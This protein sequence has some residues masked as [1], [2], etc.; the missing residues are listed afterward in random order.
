MRGAVFFSARDLAGDRR[1]FATKIGRSHYARPAIIPAA[2]K[3][4][5]PAPPSE[6]KAVT[7]RGPVSVRWHGP[8]AAASYAVY[9]VEGKK[10][11]CAPI[12]PRTLIATVRGGSATD[13]AARPGATYTYYV[14][15][16]DRTHRESV[17]AKGAT[18]TVP[19]G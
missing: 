4:R 12:D 17:P 2:G 9:R 18:I 13:P 15:A 14:T 8:G 11:A 3:G 16:L 10:A 7:G 6:I 19:G 1:G 5:A